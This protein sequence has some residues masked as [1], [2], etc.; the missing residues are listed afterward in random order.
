MAP[1]RRARQRGPRA[2]PLARDVH[3]SSGIRDHQRVMELQIAGHV[4]PTFLLLGACLRDELQALCQ[5]LALRRGT[6]VLDHGPDLKDAMDLQLAAAQL[7]SDSGN[8]QIA[9]L[10]KHGETQ[11]I[12]RVKYVAQVG[13]LR[14]RELF[15][16][17]LAPPLLLTARDAPRRRG[18]RPRLAGRG[19]GR[20]RLRHACAGRRGAPAA[21]VTPS[22]ACD[23]TLQSPPQKGRSHPL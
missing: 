8:P 20:G 14:R 11:L 3:T 6:H 13:E 18:R 22:G 10:Q 5:T 17:G 12:P 15:I 7:T 2:R 19:S 4:A 16:N 9:G 21:R 1:A 23:P